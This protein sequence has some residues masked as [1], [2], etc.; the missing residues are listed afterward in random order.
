M[1]NAALVFGDQSEEKNFDDV[2]ACAAISAS[3]IPNFLTL[4]ARRMEYD[5]HARPHYALTR[6]SE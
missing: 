6:L 4:A 1:P 2:A 5:L 3:S